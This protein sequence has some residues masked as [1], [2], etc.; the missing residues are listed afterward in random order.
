MCPIASLVL[1]FVYGWYLVGTRDKSTALLLKDRL[2]AIRMGFDFCSLA[3]GLGYI[4][5][6][7][8]S[9]MKT[10]LK[11]FLVSWLLKTNL[12]LF[13]LDGFLTYLYGRLLTV[14]VVI[15]L[16]LVLICRM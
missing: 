11:S 3:C 7:K 9:P 8:R 13:L 14:L 1:T 15:D 5:D 4:I 16:V 12:F 6:V 10:Y 2:S